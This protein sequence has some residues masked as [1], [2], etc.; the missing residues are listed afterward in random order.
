MDKSLP[1]PAWKPP[2]LQYI[3]LALKRVISSFLHNYKSEF[4]LFLSSD[5]KHEN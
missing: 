2:Y 4:E 1:S 3:S 5:T